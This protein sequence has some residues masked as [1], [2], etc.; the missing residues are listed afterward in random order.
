MVP[1]VIKNAILRQ[2]PALY[3][4]E[5]LGEYPPRFGGCIGEDIRQVGGRDE[6]Y[7]LH[8]HLPNSPY[9]YLIPIGSGC[10]QLYQP[11]ITRSSNYARGGSC[12]GCGRRVWRQ[13]YA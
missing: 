12:C 10:S 7:S 4:G 11:T 6:G 8:L 2:I 9:R 1:M 3:N 13:Y 5:R